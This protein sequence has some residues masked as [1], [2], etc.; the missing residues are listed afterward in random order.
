MQFT[1]ST[2]NINSVRL[3]IEQVGRFL[4]EH[5]RTSCACRR[6]SARTTCFRSRP[7]NPSAIPS[8][9]IWARRAITASRSCRAIRS[10]APSVMDMCGRADARHI[11]V[12]L[13]RGQRRGR[14]HD[15]QF[16]RARRRRH[17]RSGPQR[18]IPPQA[19]VHGRDAAP[20]AAART[21]PARRP[22]WWAISTWRRLRTTSGATSSSST[23]SATRR[24]RPRRSRN[25]GSRPAGSTPCAALRPEPEKIY[26]WWSYRSP[27][28]AAVDKGRRLDHI[29][30]SGD[31]AGSLRAM[32][33]TRETRG[34]ERPSDH[35]P[36]TVTLDL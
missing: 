23:W 13:A 12:T 25:C 5:A 6:P 20:G 33:I 11:A 10:R 24:S 3:R 2:W 18:E 1:V 26:S 32:N 36:V 34:W 14:H 4:G 7:C 30:L 22:F 19:S 29:W 35:V 27:D 17:P 21:P 8:W 15:P 16:L 28:W 31:L 9:S